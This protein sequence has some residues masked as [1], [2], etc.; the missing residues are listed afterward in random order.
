VAYPLAFL[1]E[2][3]AYCLG[4]DFLFRTRTPSLFGYSPPVFPLIP[5][6]SSP[7]SSLFFLTFYVHS[8][9]P[10]SEDC[11]LSTS[12][13]QTFPFY[14]IS[15]YAD[16]LRFSLSPPAFSSCGLNKLWP[17]SQGVSFLVGTSELHMDNRRCRMPSIH[18]TLVAGPGSR[19]P[20][21]LLVF[22]GSPY[23]RE[24]NT[25]ILLK[26]V[27]QAPPPAPGTRAPLLLRAKRMPV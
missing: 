2:G 3:P 12:F 19:P 6:F 11:L 21:A 14:Q 8:A 9:W 16:A 5:P 17:A 27:S 4:F 20:L 18:F 7:P 22:R 25:T 26:F 15:V 10:V 24:E 1:Q 13:L 23:L